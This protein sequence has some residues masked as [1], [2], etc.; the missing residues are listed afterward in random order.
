MATKTS[1]A[2]SSKGKSSRKAVRKPAKKAA[3][4]PARK[5][6]PGFV[7]HT[8]LAS[9][10]PPATKAWA[11][12]VLGWKF[13]PPMAMPNGSQYHMWDFGNQT[14]GGIRGNGPQ[15]PPGTVPYVEV[16]DIKA[17]HKKAVD[18]GAVSLLAPDPIPGGMGWIAV[19][20]APGGVAVGFWATK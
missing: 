1:K 6:R 13:M 2:K 8:E 3:S 11:T 4:P 10:D 17:A 19:V 15:E 7:S 12:K 14:G 9:N 18:A 20:Q 16:N 5:I